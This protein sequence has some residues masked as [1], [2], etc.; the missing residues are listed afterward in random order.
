[1][2]GAAELARMKKSAFIVNTSRGGLVDEAALAEALN[3]GLIN[4]A[5]LD[6]LE[7]EAIDMKDPLT[8]TPFPHTTTPGLVLTPHIAG[9]SEE[10]FLEAGTVAWA[11]AK[12]VL[13]GQAPKHPVNNPTLSPANA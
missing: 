4:G 10:A 11:E 8:H 12:L 1:M 7:A 13:T 2:I 3:E 6:V 5:A 9:Q